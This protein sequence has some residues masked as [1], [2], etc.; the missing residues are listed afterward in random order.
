MNNVWCNLRYNVENWE[1]QQISKIIH[2]T[3]N[4]KQAG[5]GGG[6]G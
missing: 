6:G 4:W 1:H 5:G 3:K 2:H